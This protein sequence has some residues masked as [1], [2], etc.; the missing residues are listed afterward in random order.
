[1][2]SKII[3]IKINK[4]LIISI[5]FSIFALLLN[6]YLMYKRKVKVRIKAKIKFGKIIPNDIIEI[7]QPIFI[8]II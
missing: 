1:M 6:F 2:E 8:T 5:L 4:H 7:Y 3:I